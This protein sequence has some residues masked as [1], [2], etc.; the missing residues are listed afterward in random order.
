MKRQFIHYLHSTVARRILSLFVLCALLPTATL[1]I[2]S[3]GQVANDRREQAY[4]RLHH[5]SKDISMTILDCL[6]FLKG[7]VTALDGIPPTSLRLA[8]DPLHEKLLGLTLLQPDSKTRV[9]FG[10]PCPPALVSE[11]SLKKLAS[12]KA[13]I[14]SV[15]G[16]GP[17]MRLFIAVGI[18]KHSGQ[19]GVLIGEINPGYLWERVNDALPPLT[20]AAVLN[21]RGLPLFTSRFFPK[22]AGAYLQNRPQ[23]P[24]FGEF[25]IPLT[26]KSYLGNSRLLFLQGYFLSDNWPIIVT[27][28][29]ADAFLGLTRF[30]R[31]FVLI[32]VLMLLVVCY[33]SSVQIR[34]SMVPLTRLMEGTH[35][36]SHGDFTSRIQV[37]S[38]D[39]FEEVA[40]SF[41]M[42]AE[43]L[44][45]QFE[46]LSETGQFVRTILTALDRKK[47]IS[48]VISQM[49]TVISCDQVALFLLD[50][51]LKNTAI[52]Y[53][54]N[55]GEAPAYTNV[56]PE[57]LDRLRQ[58][59]ECLLAEPGEFPGLLATMGEDGPM[60][61]LLLPLRFHDNL[62]GLLVLRY[63]D[64]PERIE[65]DLLRARQI[66]DQI[67]VAMVNADLMDELAQ[68]SWGT[69]TALARAV[70]ANSPWTAG[71]SERV[72][73]L[74]LKIG[75]E[76]GL[77]PEE[78][79]LLHQGGLL[80]DIGKIAV[81]GAILDKAGPLTNEEF[82]MVRQHPATGV[83]I[84]EPIPP[85]R[86][87]IPLVEQHHEWF[88]GK[89]YPHGLAGEALSLGARILAVAD[90]YDALLSDRP[91]RPGWKFDAVVAYIEERAGQQFDPAVVEAFLHICRDPVPGDGGTGHR[92]DSA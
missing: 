28:S 38:G 24:S 5:A 77:S 20:E 45:R 11:P 33:L 10:K 25:Q 34:R 3:L 88:N 64:K 91:Y 50:P 9:L 70:D 7:E 15:P 18:G 1:G 22:G 83:L 74:A 35:R 92:Q 42:M 37:K 43:H 68:L 81:P 69:L 30:A 82:A 80:H 27:Q 75:K 17:Q 87:V 4:E 47:I 63:R 13:Q 90:V 6:T 86:D 52:A 61:H 44:R 79:A 57:E 36:I 84:L 31:T 67:A 62:D 71:H 46:T 89:G 58:I 8:R 76:L 2:F 19:P 72:T 78:Q 48:A 54:S 23:Q 40:D 12:G 60:T 51:G 53:H 65:E 73:E 41:N 49:Q 16:N 66:T 32:L 56:P 26:G 55:G 85:Y 29:K 21:G 14:R 59:S 39:E